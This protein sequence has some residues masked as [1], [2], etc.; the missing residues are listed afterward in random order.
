[1]LIAGAGGHAMEIVD[2][3]SENERKSCFLYDDVTKDLPAYINE[4]P[5][6]STADHAAEILKND[7]AFVLG[8][9][10]GKLRQHF[11]ATFRAA[12]GTL[13]TVISP[14]AFCSKD[15]TIGE[16]ANIMAFAFVSSGVVTGEGCL[17]NTRANIHHNV[18][19]GDYCEISP[20]AVLLGN[21]KIGSFA[22]VGAGAIILPGI[23]VGEGAIIGAGA[24]V[25][26]NVAPGVTVAGN[27]AKPI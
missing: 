6:C 25:T 13:T 22:S 19:L 15:A 10:D 18:V 17:I 20:A 12:G 16:G 7:P 1:M 24:V 23:E 3:L 21:V 8:V 9:G 14:L 2:I 5:V 11:A 27:P 4:I 26:K